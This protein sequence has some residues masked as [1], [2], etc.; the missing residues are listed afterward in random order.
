[1]S[2]NS[3]NP[4]LIPFKTMIMYNAV[5]SSVVTQ[6]YREMINSFHVSLHCR[7]IRKRII[8]L[9]YCL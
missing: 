1:M 5:T 7:Y 6:S 4:H 3:V 2:V 8:L 9:I